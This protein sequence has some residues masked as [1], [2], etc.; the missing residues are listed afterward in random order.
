M[1]SPDTRSRWPDSYDYIQVRR[2]KLPYWKAGKADGVLDQA[3][4]I[5]QFLPVSPLRLAAVFDGK[6][7]QAVLGVVPKGRHDLLI[8]P[9][10]LA[11]AGETYFFYNANW[12]NCRVFYDGPL[13]PRKRKT[14][15]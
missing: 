1:P 15:K 10:G 8:D 2:S 3:C 11:R 14:R 12:G 13:E 4:R 9:E 5:G 7:G 6:E